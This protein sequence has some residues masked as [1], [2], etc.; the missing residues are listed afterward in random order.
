MTGPKAR[1]WDA[2]LLLALIWGSSFLFIKVAVGV[3]PPAY[4]A[5]GRIAIGAVT[6]LVVLAATRQRLSRSPAVWGH[7]AV[8]AALVNVAPFMLFSWGEQHVSSVVAGIFN[9]VTPVLAM[10]VAL[11]A[12]PDERPGRQRLVGL[13]IGF[14]GVLVVLGVWRTSDGQDLAGQLACL[15]A[16]ACYA[17]GFPYAKRTLAGRSESSVEL[18]AVQIVVGTVEAAVVAPLV[19]GGLPDSTRG[20]W[21]PSVVGSMLALGVLGTG[22]AYLL[23][24]R[25]IRRAGV[26]AASTVTY[27]M[28]LVSVAAGVLLLGEHVTWNQPAGALVV[29]L[30]VA[31]AQ[32][33]LK[34]RRDQALV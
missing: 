15:A 34:R 3:I 10:L 20:W 8:T 26:V 31:V 32:G 17:L 12:L 6:L 18:S 24:Y 27:L 5:L 16:A 22:L 23:N 29:L 14:A 28:P 1:W 7:S 19:S 2:L 25:I 4:V 21:T 30:G 13:P 11:V 9:A 33:V